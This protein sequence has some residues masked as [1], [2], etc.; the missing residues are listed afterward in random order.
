MVTYTTQNLLIDSNVNWSA[1]GA[2]KHTRCFIRDDTAR[3]APLSLS[4]SL[5]LSLPPSL[6]PSLSLSFFLSLFPSISLSLSRRGRR[7]SRTPS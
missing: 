1:D 2:F 6:P 4:F 3:K 5:S 7:S